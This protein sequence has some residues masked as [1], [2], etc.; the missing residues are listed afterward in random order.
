MARLP[1][2]VA[3]KSPRVEALCAVP[4]P[5]LPSCVIQRSLLTRKKAMYWAITFLN[6]T[7]WATF[8]YISATELRHRPYAALILP[9]CWL[10]W[11]SRVRGI[12]DFDAY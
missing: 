1:F 6:W 10:K 8:F 11:M 7:G 4:T 3:F 2:S 9:Q 12:R 5:L